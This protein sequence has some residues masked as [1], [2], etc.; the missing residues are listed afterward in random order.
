MVAAEKDTA[1]AFDPA[2]F[3]C[4]RDAV[5]VRLAVAGV[6]DLRADDFAVPVFFVPVFGPADVLDVDVCFAAADVAFFLPD[7][8]VVAV[9]LAA[10]ALAA[11][12][13]FRVVVVVPF[14]V[15]VDRELDRPDLVDVDWARVVFLRSAPAGSFLRAD[16]LAAERCPVCASFLVTRLRPPVRRPFST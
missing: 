2:D 14:F 16:V 10:F 12:R 5:A 13:A 9:A 11:G 6:L 15:P 3:G 1:G 7:F 4:L 8:V